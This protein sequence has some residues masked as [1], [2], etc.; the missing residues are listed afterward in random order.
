MTQTLM[1][2]GG[3]YLIFLSLW[4]LA[5]VRAAVEDARDELQ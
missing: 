1:A 4:I 3:M 5:V 2:L